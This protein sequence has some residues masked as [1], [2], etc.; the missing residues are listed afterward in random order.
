[1]QQT[2]KLMTSGSDQCVVL[3]PEF[4]FDTSEVSIRRD[5]KTGE[6]ILSPRLTWEE[7]FQGL[8]QAGVPDDFLRPEDRDPYW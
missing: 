1:M 5:E 8:D 4:R 3:P 7:I 2:A 6:V